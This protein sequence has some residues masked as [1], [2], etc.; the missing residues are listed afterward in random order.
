MNILFLADPNAVH[1]L[2]WMSWFS[3]VHSCFLVAREQH[4]EGWTAGSRRKF[5]EETNIEILGSIADFSIRHFFRNKGGFDK[6]RQ[7][8][9]EHSIDVFHILY[10]EPNGL[11]AYYRQKLEVPVVIS[12]RGSDVLMGIR[13]FFR[14]KDPLA[15]LLRYFYRKSFRA[16]D[17]VTSTS[18]FQKK[19]IQRM[20]GREEAEII[21]TGVELEK[22]QESDLACLPAEIPADRPFVFFPRLMK[23]VYRHEFSIE[24]IG[25]L[26]EHIKSSFSFVFVGANGPE[27]EYIDKIS[28]LMEKQK[29]VDFIFLNRQSR[30]A[31]YALYKK[32]ALVVMNPVSD[33]T[34][35]SAMEAMACKTPVIMPPL[36]YDPAL[37]NEQT[38]TFFEAWNPGSLEKSMRKLLET[39][40]RSHAKVETAFETVGL[41]G[42][43]STNMKKLESLLKSLLNKPPGGNERK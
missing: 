24:A 4:L 29:G 14:R 12:T 5:K 3:G 30:Q 10:A 28:N 17:L 34:P 32:A 16:A 23:P 43:Y 2:K 19:E 13:G 25:L 9:K 42:D 6:L 11:W 22:L 40:E 37:F 7:M 41:N 20:L 33:G 39:P 1:D 38:V 36:Q 35:V 26:P 21:Y 8:L 27:T 15:L 18:S 31:L